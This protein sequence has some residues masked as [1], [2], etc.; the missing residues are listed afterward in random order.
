[1]SFRQIVDALLPQRDVS[2]E[3]E[4]LGCTQTILNGAMPW[5]HVDYHEHGVDDATAHS[6]DLEAAESCASMSNPT[7]LP[8]RYEGRRSFTSATDHVDQLLE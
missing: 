3:A 4:V 5:I 1:M 6:R 7:C 8:G 2:K